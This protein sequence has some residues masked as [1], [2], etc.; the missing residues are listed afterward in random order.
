MSNAAKAD[1]IPSLNIETD[2]VKCSHG[3]TSGKI[4]E[5]QIYY[6]QCRGFSRSDAEELLIFGYFEE[7][8]GGLPERAQAN[9]RQLIQRRFRANGQ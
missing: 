8:I 1:S 5:E 9:V 6:F 4:D 7:L 3:S 2:D